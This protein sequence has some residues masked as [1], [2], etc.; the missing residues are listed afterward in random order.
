MIELSL[1]M[2]IAIVC[3]ILLLVMALFG[4]DFLD[5]DVDADV[6]TD[7][8]L[9]GHFE[10]GHGDFSAG[11]SPLSLPLVLCFGTSFGAFGVIFDAAGFGAVWTPVGSTLV[12]IVIAAIMFYVLVKVFIQTQATTQVTF[13][14]LI[15]KEGVVTIPIR[16]GEQGQIRVDTEERG[17][18]LI[19]A[20]ADEDIATDALI[21]IERMSG[22]TAIVKRKKGL[23]E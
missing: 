21:T 20:I 2:I 16:P 19:T 18:T 5:L 10:A 23:V 13:K 14:K 12:S 6:D 1:Y 22:N 7:M 15:G 3:G 9:G 17:R 11:L 8:D 4:G